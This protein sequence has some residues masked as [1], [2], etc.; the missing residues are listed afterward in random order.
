MLRNNSADKLPDGWR[1]RK[2]CVNDLKW[3]FF[4]TQNLIRFDA[5]ILIKSFIFSKAGLHSKYCWNQRVC[6]TKRGERR[7]VFST[8]RNIKFDWFPSKCLMP[9]GRCHKSC[10][11]CNKFPR[12]SSSLWLL[13]DSPISLVG[14]VVDWQWSS[15]RLKDLNFDSSRFDEISPSNKLSDVVLNLNVASALLTQDI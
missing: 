2:R 6:I 9:F 5:I 12:I 11:A 8:P 3:F 7:S 4:F 14:L 10:Q 15:C 13:N 1:Q